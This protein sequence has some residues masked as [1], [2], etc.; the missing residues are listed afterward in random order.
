MEKI[1]IRMP[2]IDRITVAQKIRAKYFNKKDYKP[3]NIYGKELG[4][5]RTKGL[6]DLKLKWNEA[7]YL[8]DSITEERIIANPIKAG[9]ERSWVINFQ[10]I[11][12]N[13][14]REHVRNNYINKLKELLTPWVEEIPV[15]TEF[16]LKIEFFIYSVEMPIDVGNKGPVY[17]KVFEDILKINKIPD[18]SS[19]YIRDTGRCVWTPTPKHKE[20]M[21]FH[22]SKTE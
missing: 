17:Y 1:I 15:I 16:P 6:E 4:S 11:Y 3:F 20:R 14:I 13:R 7:G 21:E 5:R 22:I 19:E 2:Y 10:D 18:D 8:V 9:K 12:N